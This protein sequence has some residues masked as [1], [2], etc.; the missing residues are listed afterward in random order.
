MGV[1]VNRSRVRSCGWGALTRL[2]TLL[3][4]VTWF[5][6]YDPLVSSFNALS[7]VSFV[8]TIPLLV[9]GAYCLDLLERKTEHL[10]SIKQSQVHDGP[11]WASESSWAASPQ[12]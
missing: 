10:S 5:V 1:A 9:F 2:G 11:V 12:S 6:H 7:I 8:L 4:A 3:I